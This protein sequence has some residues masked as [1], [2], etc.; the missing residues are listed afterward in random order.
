MVLKEYG[1]AREL[2]GE[3]G[4]VRGCGEVSDLAFGPRAGACPPCVFVS[5]CAS[6][7]L[8]RGAAA[9]ERMGSWLTSLCGEGP[10]RVTHDGSAVGPV[11]AARG[12]PCL[13]RTSS[14]SR[15]SGTVPRASSSWPGRAPIFGIGLTAAQSESDILR[16][17]SF[18]AGLEARIRWGCAWRPAGATWSR[19]ASLP[20]ITSSIVAGRRG[21]RESSWSARRLSPLA[22]CWVSS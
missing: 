1:A 9:V 21:R 4:V 22:L 6:G 13:Q 2:G 18:G 15:P 8:T 20:S 12:A 7:R 10:R 14:C 11:G 17:R 3:G 5:R 19:P 16:P